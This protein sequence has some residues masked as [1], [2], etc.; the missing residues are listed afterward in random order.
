L[1]YAAKIAA[2]N[3]RPEEAKAFLNRALKNTTPWTTKADAKAFLEQLN[4]N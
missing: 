2:A 4:K 3:K 1:Y